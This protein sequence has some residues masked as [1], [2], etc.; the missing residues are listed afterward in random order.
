MLTTAG[1]IVRIKLGPFT[2]AVSPAVHGAAGD[3][4]DPGGAIPWSVEIVF[5]VCVIGEKF[6]IRVEPCRQKYSGNP[7]IRSPSLYRRVRFCI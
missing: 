6:A 2:G 7:R 5:H 3:M 1:K 4:I